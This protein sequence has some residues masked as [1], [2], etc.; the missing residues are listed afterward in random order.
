MKTSLR[1]YFSKIGSRGGRTSRRALNTATARTMVRI[2]EARRAYLR[3]YAQCFWSC[4]PGLKISESDLPWVA[5]QLRKNGG[6]A[7][8]LCAD[9]LCR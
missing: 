3:F 6:R 5:E 9:K 4:P 7:A 2:R 1:K 8:W